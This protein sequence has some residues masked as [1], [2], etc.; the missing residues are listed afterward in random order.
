MKTFEF[1]PES[2]FIFFEINE[3]GNEHAPSGERTA[4]SADTIKIL[5]NVLSR[6]PIRHQLIMRRRNGLRSNVRRTPY[7]LRVGVFKQPFD[8]EEAYESMDEFHSALTAFWDREESLPFVEQMAVIKDLLARSPVPIESLEGKNP[9]GQF[10]AFSGAT[11]IHPSSSNPT[12]LKI[13][14]TELQIGSVSK[15][16]LLS[17]IDLAAF[18]I[19]L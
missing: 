7:Q 11:L 3:A 15:D 9:L 14:L 17:K 1:I 8:L 5:E 19:A 6:L 4:L 16:L 12:I 18:S 13:S 10:L 2:L